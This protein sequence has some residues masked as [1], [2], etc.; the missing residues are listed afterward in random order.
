MM[1]TVRRL[2]VGLAVV[3]A[4]HGA[5]LAAAAQEDGAVAEQ[6]AA[7]APPPA[8]PRPLGW[9]DDSRRP[10]EGPLDALLSGRVLLNNRLR[11]EFAD[12]S[13]AD[14]SLAITNRLRLGYETRP[15]YGLT[16]LVE[17][18][19][20]FTPRDEDYFVPQTGDGSSEKTPIADPPGTEM[21]RAQLRW[22]RDGMF[23]DRLWVEI[24]GGR[25]R[26]L[27]DDERF[28]GNVGWRQFEQTFDSISLRSNLGLEKLEATYAYIWEVRRIFGP[29]GPN[30]ES[31]S[32][33]L[34]ASY[35]FAQQFK[36]TGFLYA[37]DF[38]DD[39]PSDST[40]TYGARASGVIPTE[41]MWGQ[42]A[43]FD[44]ALTY[45]YQT[46]AGGNPVDFETEFIGA[47]IGAARPELGKLTI[48]YQILGSD[49]GDFGFRFPLGT[50]HKFQ[51]FADQFVVTP[52]GGLHDLYA[53]IEAELPWDLRPALSF[54][55]FW[56]EQSGDDL[57]Y[58]V[59]FV[60]GRQFTPNWSG[61]VKAAWFDGNNGQPD[62][63]RLWLETTL[64]F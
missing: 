43:T 47:E 56:S 31:D 15:W 39:S 25:Q 6:S 48:G 55:Q 59:D 1:L 41:G 12:T 23:E 44:Y 49:G 7:A 36:L 64:S 35:A 16:G 63:V 20:V 30:W 45:A 50:N 14:H 53:T 4:A 9:L 10:A 3:S 18:E 19:N 22:R 17:M 28:V 32:H 34:N 37:L 40:N 5:Q 61:L 33:L 46:D 26:I 2:G 57:G 8:E 27:L 21:N 62:T 42:R 38:E 11:A 52:A 29:D 60:L 54:H 51:G 13:G 24:T 58:E